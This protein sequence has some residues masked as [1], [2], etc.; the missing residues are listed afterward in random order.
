MLPTPLTKTP[1]RART[2][3]GTQDGLRA[4]ATAVTAISPALHHDAHTAVCA[5]VRVLC[6]RRAHLWK[7]QGPLPSLLTLTHLRRTYR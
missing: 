5:H 4:L 3:P 7:T 2:G 6:V 1:G